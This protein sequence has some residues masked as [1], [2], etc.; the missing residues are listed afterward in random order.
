MESLKD[1]SEII[2]IVA[3]L[4]SVLS[5]LVAGRSTILVEKLRKQTRNEDMRIKILQEF[6]LYM[7]EKFDGMDAIAESREGP[8]MNKD[9]T[10]SVMRLLNQVTN[11]YREISY[12]FS[13]SSKEAIDNTLLFIEREAGSSE[14]W[15]QLE[16]L[17]QLYKQYVSNELSKLLSNS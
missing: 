6:Q 7:K 1:Y 8:S 11:R 4:V 2:A 17:P 13:S 16:N 5:A 3:L 15:Q 10:M 9:E 12:V 14:A